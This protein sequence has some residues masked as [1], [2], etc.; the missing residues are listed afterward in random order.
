MPA[1]RHSPVVFHFKTICL[2][3]RPTSSQVTPTSLSCRVY[4]HHCA[5]FV[6][7][8]IPAVIVPPSFPSR[9]RHHRVQL[10]PLMRGTRRPSARPLLAFRST[11][12]QEGWN[13]ALLDLPEGEGA[14]GFAYTSEPRPRATSRH[15]CGAGPLGKPRAVGVRP[16]R[17]RFPPPALRPS[18][19]TKCYTSLP[20][21][22]AAGRAVVESWLAS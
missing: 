8:A 9:A 21:S 10:H 22:E 2:I 15:D 3:V 11:T 19:R 5:P 16:P 4:P 20:R 18:T 17:R 14:P 1:T 6:I 7:P 12:P 13:Q